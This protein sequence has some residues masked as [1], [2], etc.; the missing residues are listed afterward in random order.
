MTSPTLTDAELLSTCVPDETGPLLENQVTSEFA[1]A[2][3]ASPGASGV[4]QCRKLAVV[5]SEPTFAFIP[6]GG[7]LPSTPAAIA[8]ME[9]IKYETVGGTVDVSGDL[10][11][12]IP[13][14]FSVEARL[15]AALIGKFLAAMN[16]AESPPAG[17]RNVPY[18][19]SQNPAGVMLPSAGVG[20]P[21]VIA[22]VLAMRRRVLP[23]GSDPSIVL[24]MGTKTFE[25][26]EKSAA[27]EQHP[28]EYRLL[29]D[30]VTYAPYVAMSRVLL[31]DNV[32]TTESGHPDRTS[33]YAVRLKGG[34]PRTG[35]RGLSLEF[36]PGRAGVQV[37]P[38]TPDEHDDLRRVAVWSTVAMVAGR[39]DVARLSSLSTLTVPA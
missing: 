32:P 37:G 21:P 36:P 27:A 38:S 12:Q 20:S 35:I 33:I 14:A 18:W 1:D 11:D 15:F 29:A 2:L 28:I 24:A 26:L 22:D 5:S 17:W 3:N 39:T 25:A 23:H 4:T 31:D 9:N 19:A 7:T 10:V 34:A 30:G 8:T 6:S 13:Q 16:F